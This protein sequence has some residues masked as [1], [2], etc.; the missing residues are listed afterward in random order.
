MCE[1]CN[2]NDA[3]DIHHLQYQQDADDDN[4]IITNQITFHKNHTANLASVCKDCHDQIHRDNIRMKRVKTSK[5][6]VLNKI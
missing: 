3:S 2:M 5:G 6:Y 1:I 4:M